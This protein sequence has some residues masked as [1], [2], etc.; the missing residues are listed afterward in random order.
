M[1]RNIL[2][3]VEGEADKRF[4]EDFIAVHFPAHPHELRIETI[5]GIGNLFSSIISGKLR[6]NA[7]KYP[8]TYCNLVFVDADDTVRNHGIPAG[9]ELR[10]AYLAR[11]REMQRMS[12]DAFIFPNNAAAEG[13]L[14]TLLEQLV[15]PSFR[16]SFNCIETYRACLAAIRDTDKAVPFV[17][18]PDDK[19]RFFIYCYLHS[20]APNH[21]ETKRSYIDSPLW[22]LH[23]QE[24]PYV[25]A[26]H[27]FL[28]Q[29]FSPKSDI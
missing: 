2:I 9:Y 22:T 10:S 12:F 15:A 26:L 21:G 27:A 24:N 13:T 28:A 6:A 16:A 3:T 18:F 17:N 11:Q 8:E 5:G 20:T 14:E 1:K 29:Y 4:L 25:A 23:D 19:Q 7:D